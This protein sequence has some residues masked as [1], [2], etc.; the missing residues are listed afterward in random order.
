MFFL[1]D[2]PEIR[3]IFVWK[4]GSGKNRTGTR[5]LGQNVFPKSLFQ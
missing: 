4:T 3:M 2:L 5:I 1:D